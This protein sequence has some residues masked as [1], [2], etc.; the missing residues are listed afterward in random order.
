MK[1]LIGTVVL[2]AALVAGG[3]AGLAR[4]GELKA[5]YTY[6]GRDVVI[7][8]VSESGR[9]APGKNAFVL[10]FVSAATKQ[11]VDAGTVTLSASMAMPG[12]APMVDGASLTPDKTAGRYLGTIDVPDRGTRQVTITWNGPAAKGS[13]RFSVPVR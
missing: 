10:E 8:L 5:V 4:A 1:R 13:T 6:K 3:L 2:G 11:P 12:M 7:A 9:F